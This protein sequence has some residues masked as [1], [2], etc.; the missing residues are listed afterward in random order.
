MEN[1]IQQQLEALEAEYAKK[2]QDLINSQYVGKCWTNGYRKFKCT[3]IGKSGNLFG[4]GFNFADEYFNTQD[5]ES[6]FCAMNALGI[7]DLKPL[8]ESEFAKLMEAEAIRLGLVAGAKVDRGELKCIDE[9]EE[10]KVQV[11]DGHYYFIN[12]AFILNG[13]V[14]FENGIW[15]K[16]VEQ[17]K[18]K[19]LGDWALLFDEYVFERSASPSIGFKDFLLK[20]NLKLIENVKPKTQ[21]NELKTFNDFPKKSGKYLIYGRYSK[22]SPKNV[23]QASYCVGDKFRTDIICK[24]VTHWMPLPDAP[25]S[26][27]ETS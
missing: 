21:W 14:I 17:P 9:S 13:W 23:F 16:V 8:P 18:P 25:I 15:A 6:K 26:T 19:T 22:D 11:D 2:K 7:R 24:D 27:T 20:N 10:F 12:D 3:F 1:N 5:E 4:Y